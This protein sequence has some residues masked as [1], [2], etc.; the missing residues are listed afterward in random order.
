MTNLIWDDCDDHTSPNWYGWKFYGG[1]PASIG[2][3]TAPR[4]YRS[5]L[6]DACHRANEQSVLRD[7]ALRDDVRAC[8]REL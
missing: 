7:E 5:H 4:H 8:S 6:M 3:Q 1:V 2:Q